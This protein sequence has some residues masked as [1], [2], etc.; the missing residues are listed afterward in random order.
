MLDDQDFRHGQRTAGFLDEYVS[1]PAFLSLFPPCFL[2]YVLIFSIQFTSSF[3]SSSFPHIRPFVQLPDVHTKVIFLSSLMLCT[4][5]VCVH[6]LCIQ[7]ISLS[8]FENERLS[9]GR[10]PDGFGQGW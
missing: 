9:D 6:T 10:I 3:L 5:R 4:I 1:F 8:R 2:L 7:I